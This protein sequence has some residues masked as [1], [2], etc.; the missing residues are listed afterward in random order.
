MRTT[1]GFERVDVIYRRIDDDFLDPKTFRPDSMLGVPGLMDVYRAGRVALAN[2]PG[3]GVA[4]DKVVYAY[5]PKIMKYY[6]GEE[7]ILPN[8]PTYI[9]AD[10]DER[11]VRAGAPG[12]AG[13]EGGQRIRRLRHAGGPALDEGAAGGVRRAD[14]SRPAQLHRAADAVAVARADDRGRRVRGRH[15]DLRPY[16]LYG[17]DIFVLPGGLTR[18]A[19]KRLAGRQLVAGRRQ[20]GHVGARG[21][22]AATAERRRRQSQANAAQAERNPNARRVA[23]AIYWMSR[24]IERAENVARFIDV[25]LHLMLD[26]PAAPPS[27]GSRWSPPPATR[28]RSRAVRRGDAQQRHPV[29]HV[30]PRESELDPLVPAGGARERPLRARDHLV[31]DVGAAQRVLPDGERA[32]TPE[33]APTRRT[34]SRRSRG[35]PAVRRHHRR[36]DDP[37]RELALLPARADARARRQDV[38]HPRREVLPPAAHADDVG[39]TSDD[40]Q[41]AAVLRSASAFEMYRKRHGRIAP[42]R[43]V[44]FLLL[45]KEFPRAIRYCLVRARESLHAISGTPA[46]SSAPG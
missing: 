6:L 2:A 5:V 25:N 30:R 43:V 4:D 17:K 42:E 24:Y 21:R 26:L 40:I 46:G 8:V 37:R 14:R 31:G 11:Q 27:S 33:A 28:R 16:I 45:D 44:E 18:V 12:R 39:T 10:E 35:E 38:A 23:D 20:Q 13:G 3:T 29:P 7:I 36:D 32:A 1:K 19:L 34:S 9:C 15:V 22:S 41:W